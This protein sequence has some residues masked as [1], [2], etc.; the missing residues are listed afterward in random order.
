[1][2]SL[3]LMLSVGQTTI[4]PP[5]TSPPFGFEAPLEPIRVEGVPAIA[6]VG[7]QVTSVW[8]D[9]RRGL[10]QLDAG[11]DVW[12]GRLSSGAEAFSAV[13]LTP[14]PRACS[15]VG[16]GPGDS[17]FLATWACIEPDAGL[18]EQ[19]ELLPPA[20][21]HLPSLTRTEQAVPT[22]DLRTI[23]SPSRV[24]TTA[25]HPTSVWVLQRVPPVNSVLIFGGFT[26]QS[27]VFTADGGPSLLTTDAMG[28]VSAFELLLGGSY[29]GPTLVGTNARRVIGIPGKPA[30]TFF[31]ETA[32]RQVIRR[33]PALDVLTNRANLS[34]AEPVVAPLPNAAVAIFVTDAGL[35][36][37]VVF[38]DAGTSSSHLSNGGTPLAVAGAFPTFVIAERTGREVK[39]RPLTFASTLVA[40]F[41]IAGPAFQAP[42]PQVGLSAAWSDNDRGFLVMWDQRDGG[43][44][45]T[46]AGVVDNG[47]NNDLGEFS[48]SA[49]PARPVVAPAPDGGHYVAITEDTG[50]ALY[51]VVGGMRGSKAATS[52]LDEVVVGTSSHVS[53]NPAGGLLLHSVGTSLMTTVPPGC[54]AW[55]QGIYAL[56]SQGFVTEIS[57]GGV[58][59][60]TQPLP[61]L[62]AVAPPLTRQCLVAN[63]TGTRFVITST[64]SSISVHEVAPQRHL[65]T[66]SIPLAAP[67]ASVA[68]GDGV[69]VV[70]GLVPDGQRGTV[71]WLYFTRPFTSS[72]E[73]STDTQPVRNVR[74]VSAPNGDVLASWETFQ[75]D[76]G[77]WQVQMRVIPGLF[78]PLTAPDAG[79]P[80]AGGPDAGVL[81]AGVPD[82]GVPDA[83]VPDGGAPD[84][85]DRDGGAPD[86]GVPDAS[87]PDAGIPDASVPVSDA[88]VPDASVPDAGGVVVFVPVCGCSSSD[89]LPFALVAL[90]LLM[91]GRR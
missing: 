14:S 27:L 33:F 65:D 42:R 83:G 20:A 60:V 1:M 41:G 16:L 43:A 24:I 40:N 77:A 57:E 91:R 47:G 26:N 51:E 90:L 11:F 63:Q 29:L 84:A 46:R 54:V 67:P 15:S 88:G 66:M 28:N 8:L 9:R 19:V 23:S 52:V 12:A 59:S 64:N 44:W 13:L 18:I 75:L 22:L 89:A 37:N 50:R 4:I 36:A 86:A 34:A 17:G 70:A 3:L 72:G 69:V 56:A 71:R 45:H 21:S 39:V 31:Y 5:I 76:A 49:G 74:A 6:V 2:L 87:V 58:V 25:R 61:P 81:D 73:L 48:G 38:D 80:D 30:D 62:P 68:A 82:A 53:W 35:S 10:D 78:L 7:S 32:A 79:A 55:R 85:G